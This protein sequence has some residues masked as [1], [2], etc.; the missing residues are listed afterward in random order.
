MCLTGSKALIIL[1]I[2]LDMAVMS[3][4]IEIHMTSGHTLQCSQHIGVVHLLSTH[5]FLHG[6]L[7]L[8]WHIL[9]DLH[10]ISS[11]SGLHQSLY[12]E[13]H[14]KGKRIGLIKKFYHVIQLSFGGI[15]RRCARQMSGIMMMA[16]S[17]LGCRSSVLDL[18]I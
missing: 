10:V 11:R 14:C 5:N 2:L 12:T 6:V 4:A 9:H 15:D 8:G 3:V 13:N 1:D 17:S 18:S 7:T 16:A